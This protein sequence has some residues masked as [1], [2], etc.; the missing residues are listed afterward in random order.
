MWLIGEAAREQTRR[1]WVT[2]SRLAARFLDALQGLATLRALGPAGDEADAIARASERHRAVT[3]GRPA[4]RL[5]L[6]ALVLEALATLGT[7]VVAVEVGLRLLYARVGF[8]A[9]RSSS[10][11]SPPSSYRPLRALGAAFHAGMAGKEAAARIAEVLEA[12]GPLA[13]PAVLEG[14]KPP[15]P[16]R[17]PSP[18]PP[19]SASRASASR[20]VPSREPA[21]DGFT[22]ALPRGATVALVGPSGSGKTTTAR[23]LLRFLEPDHG[24][25]TVDGAP[26]AALAPE[27]WRPERGL[28]PPAAAPLPRQ[29][30]RE[31]PPRSPRRLVCCNSSKRRRGPTSTRC[32]V[33]CPGGGRRPWAREASGSPGDRPSGS[34]SPA[35]GL[36]DAP[37]LVL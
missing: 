37:V 33:N 15:C 17:R 3:M 12:E 29:P 19:R 32:S 11:S 8:P 36:K 20:T 14:P 21:L 22:L 30:P 28:R 18:R 31:R 7:A 13:A 34:P 26:L 10:S 2:L 23:L 9:R 25:I 6:P 1:Q 5:R 24:S 27:E 16:R 35:P 4:P